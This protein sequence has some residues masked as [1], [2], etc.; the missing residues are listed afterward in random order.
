MDGGFWLN[1][2]QRQ[3]WYVQPSPKHS[4]IKYHVALALDAIR[5]ETVVFLYVGY[6]RLA[7]QVAIYP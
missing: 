7:G 3:R 1:R 6:L 5:L 2:Q 4:A